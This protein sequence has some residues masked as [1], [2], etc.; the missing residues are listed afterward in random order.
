MAG[1]QYQ[2]DPN[3]YR[4]VMPKYLENN[5]GF[6]YAIRLGDYIKIGKTK[7]VDRRIR[8]YENLP[9]F[10]VEVIIAEV[11]PDQNFFERALQM[12]FIEFQVKGEWFN[13][14]Q[15]DMDYKEEILTEYNRILKQVM[16][17]SVFDGYWS[18]VEDSFNEYA[19]KK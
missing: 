19:R 8:T 1:N 9:P 14:P 7:D 4:I 18:K 16:D 3:K 6:I 5:F 15:Y 2:A 12:Y 10:N 17:N 13:M 11:V